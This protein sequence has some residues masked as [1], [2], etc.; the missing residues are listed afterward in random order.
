MQ[1][2]GPDKTNTDKQTSTPALIHAEVNETTGMTSRETNPDF[3]LV[4]FNQ[5]DPDLERCGNPWNCIDLCRRNMQ[6]Q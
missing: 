6:E 1:R 2:W 3:A 5:G 4:R